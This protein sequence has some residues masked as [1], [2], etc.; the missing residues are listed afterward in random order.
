MYVLSFEIHEDSPFS[1]MKIWYN[2]VLLP[3]TIWKKNQVFSA[4]G[5]AAGKGIDIRSAIGKLVKLIV[6]HEM[7]EG[8]ARPR[9]DRILPAEGSVDVNPMGFE[10]GPVPGI[11]DVTEKLPF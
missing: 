9:I 1:G 2:L 8:D 6:I 7:Y 5:L 11:V 10:T 4:L 3:Q